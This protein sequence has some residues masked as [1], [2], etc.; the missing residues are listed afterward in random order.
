[1]V[2]FLG[3]RLIGLIFVVI[4]V[5]FITFIMGY[6]APGDPIRVQM[7][8]HFDPLL[9]ARLRHSYGLD[10]PWYQQYYNFLVE[11]FRLDFGR[12]FKYPGRTAWDI[13]SSGVPV[14]TELSFWALLLQVIIGLPLGILSALKAN[15][16]VDTLIMVVSL[17]L[18]AMP[19][20]VLVVFLQV[21]IV[22]IDQATG[23]TWPIAN[24]GTPWQY[25]W[26]DIQYKIGPIL[27]FA[28]AG[29]A[30]FSRLARTSILEVLRQDYVRTARA[31]GMRERV[32]IYRHAL[33]NALIPLVT[34]LGLSIGLLVT[35]VFFIET[36]F[37]IPGVAYAT[38]SSISDLDYPVIQATTVLS[39]VAVVVGNFIADLLY[40]VVDPRIRA[41]QER[42]TWR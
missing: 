35:G 18:Y 20:F 42:G 32:V 5:T 12:S 40:T 37:N 1:M 3:K 41:Q 14:S 23:V 17:T 15:T 11:L 2:Q 24:W 19:V 25:S 28:A 31:K 36:I 13:L 30:Y 33:R 38:V 26:S 22:Q 29:F 16:W 7:G 8:Q 21:A 6:F 10:L 34:V 9:Y 27:V 4:G 39:A